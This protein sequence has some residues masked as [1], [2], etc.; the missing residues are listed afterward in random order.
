MADASAGSPPR[1][2][3][4]EGLFLLAIFAGIYHAASFLLSAGYLPPPFVYDANDTYMDWY[5]SAYFA[6]NGGA[7]DIWHSIY[8]PISFV[9]LKI[10]TLHACYQGDAFAGRDCDW[11][12]RATLVALFLLNAILVFLAFRKVDRRTALVRAAAMSLGLPM[13]FTLERGNL[14]L[15]AFTVFVLGFGRVLRSARL[16]WLAVGLAVNFKPYLLAAVV[17]YLLRRRWRW[18]E[19]AAVACLLVY[20]VSYA[21]I[22]AGSPGELLA[23]ITGYVSGGGNSYFGALYY[24]ASYVSILNYLHFGIPLLRFVGSRP[25][26]V[27]E[28]VLPVLIRL[29][30][31][32]T[33]AA[34]ALAAARPRNTVPA[35]RLAAMGVALALSSTEFGGYAEVFLLFLVLQEPWCGFWRILALIAAYLLS[36]PAD[37]TLVTL[38]HHIEES[39][40]TGRTVGNDLSITLGMLLRPGLVLIIQYALTAA[41]LVDLLRPAADAQPGRGAPA[42]ALA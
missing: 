12:G 20:L 29:G 9:F 30:Q 35:H 36:I 11:L 8:P 25:L 32:T 39:W 23:D 13:I 38:A 2:R 3:L 1:G 22:G 17:P 41:T 14:I 26:E 40:L 19:G 42:P 10:F 31:V 37:Y 7:Y 6:V 33:L 34:F 16:K 28:A 27:L 18:F 21:I 15:P 5:N 4:I 24:G